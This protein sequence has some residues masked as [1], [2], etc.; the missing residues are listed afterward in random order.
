[1]TVRLDPVTFALQLE[2]ARP[3]PVQHWNQLL[4]DLIA[5]QAIGPTR[6]SRAYALFNTALYDL[7]AGL[8]P[9]AQTVYGAPSI[10]LQAGQLEPALHRLAARAELPAPRR[11]VDEE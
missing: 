2:S 8:D 7:W 4:S 10:P 11:P 3:S 9:Q 6:A 1:M 5:Q